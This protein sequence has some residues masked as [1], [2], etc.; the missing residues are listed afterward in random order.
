LG[1]RD[2]TPIAGDLFITDDNK[3]ILYA[4][5][6]LGARLE[7]NRQRESF[8]G[9]GYLGE[10]GESHYLENFLE[11][12]NKPLSELGIELDWFSNQSTSSHFTELISSGDRKFQKASE[13]D[14]LDFEA[15]RHL[16]NTITRNISLV[17]KRSG[18]ILAA[19]LF[20]K[21]ETDEEE[22]KRIVDDLIRNNLIVKEYVVI[23]KKTQNQVNRVRSLADLEKAASSGLLCSCGRSISDERVEELFIPT[24]LLQ[25]LL[26]KSYWLTVKLVEQLIGLNALPDNILLNLQEGSDEIDAFVDIDGKLLMFELKD[27]Q[28]SMGHAYPFGG[29]IGLYNPNFAVIVSTEQIEPQVKDYFGRIKPEAEIVYI[30]NLDQL[31]IKISQIT[32][33]IKSMEAV[34]ILSLFD[35][36]ASMEFTISKI[37]SQRIG[38]DY[39]KSVSREMDYL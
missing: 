29:R 26:D 37:L 21:L 32:S 19:D 8:L 31:P 36:M 1:D 5:L 3:G 10:R 6:L 16:E 13:I 38:I 39:V 24:A 15:A 9:I 20:K 14:A 30:E 34:Q 28:F 4:I 23:C 2:V 18:G 27:T 7:S 35:P 17:I 11:S 12:L 25:K 33:K 22:V